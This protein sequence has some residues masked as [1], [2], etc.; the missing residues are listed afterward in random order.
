MPQPQEPIDLTQVEDNQLSTYAEQE[1]N[2]LFPKNAYNENNKYSQ[3][4]PDALADG[5]DLGRGTGDFLD[6]NNTDAGTRT[7]INE[8]TGN[9]KINRYNNKKTYPDF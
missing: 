9:V 3:V 2:K 7:D 4:N 1:R 6:V 5:D 8:R